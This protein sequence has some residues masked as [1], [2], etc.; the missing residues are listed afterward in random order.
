MSSDE[1]LVS[2]LRSL[3][4]D[5]LTPYYDTHF[6]LLR[7]I[8]ANPGV[9]MEKIAYRLRHHLLYRACSWEIDSV[10]K[11]Q[12]GSH[13]IHRFWPRSA[14]GMSG[15]I[16]NCLVH[17]EQSGKVDFDGILDT[18]SIAEVMRARIFDIEEMLSDVM[19]IEKET[20]EQ[21]SVL[22]VMD[23]D[24]IEYTKKLIDLV[25]GSLRALSE[26]MADHYV[27]LVKYF[28]IVNVP[29]W[30]YALWMMVKPLLPERTRMKVRLLSS[31]NWRH[32]IHDL[33]DP[34]V[35]PSFWNDENH[36]E[37]KL[38]VDRPPPVPRKEITDSCEK[39][40]KL[41]VKAGQVHWM[42]YELEKGDALAFHVTG[43][44][45]VELLS[46]GNA[47]FGFTIVHG[48][49]EEEDDAFA[50]RQ[51]YPLFSWM[52][53]PLKVP[54]EDTIVVPSKGTYKLWF[55]N[56]RAWWSSLAIQHNVR[57]IKNQLTD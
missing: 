23:A 43:S 20:G 1:E 45:T 11:Q 50:M 8:Q 48:D 25:L 44:I 47:N 21:A 14:C 19:R 33:L 29:P 40:E 15:V 24:G 32:E 28:V 9:A 6:N 12:R 52:P 18:F 55:S 42:E 26:F 39:M 41:Y 54:I 37:F 27:E 4:S 16:P 13:P 46:I 36:T 35:G 51:V 17:V 5:H 31:S 38:P 53:G 56:S 57:V 10:H 3:V 22:Y 2:E 7:W 34:S 30:A 49:N